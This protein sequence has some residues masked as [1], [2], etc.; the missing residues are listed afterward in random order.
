[1]EPGAPRHR[2]WYYGGLAAVVLALVVGALAA[3]PVYHKIKQWRA[4]SLTE[5]SIQALKNNDLR[6][7]TEAA[8]AALQM[9]PND[10]R[11]VRQAAIVTERTSPARALPLWQAAWFYYHN[12]ADQRA[13]ILDA[14]NAG[15]VGAAAS[16]LKELQTRTAN[17]PQDQYVESRIY[18]ALGQW[19]DAMDAAK[20]AMDTGQGPESAQ[21]VYAL[22]AQMS[23]DEALRTREMDYLRKLTQQS[24]DLGLQALRA[25][26]T[27]QALPPADA[28]LV[29]QCLLAHPL[30]TRD[31]KLLALRLRGKFPNANDDEI[32]QTARDLFPDN[33][34]NSLVT[35]GQWLNN[36]AKY[37]QALKLVDTQ[38]AFTRKDL[39][40]IRLD[41]MAALD[42][43]AAI[44][45]LLQR[46][47]VPLPESLL[48]MFRARTQTE[49]HRGAK[50]DLAWDAVRLAT[51]NKPAELRDVAKYAA[52]LKLDDV[53]R[54][55]YQ[56]LVD[57]PEQ[58]RQA[59]ENWVG[60]ER[61]GLHTS[62][63]HQVLMKMAA[64]YPND[65]VVRNDALYT[66][67]LLGEA[68]ISQILAARQ[69]VEKTPNQLANLITLALGYLRSQPPRAADA[70]KLFDG[71][72]INWP[73]VDP[74]FQAVYIAVLRANGR[75]TEA[76][77][78]QK[79]LATGNLLSE[80][81]NLLAT[82]VGT[83]AS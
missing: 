37:E 20:R 42:Q 75:V 2:A 44:D 13:Y 79:K 52:K 45:E 77:A 17:N 47:N 7:A 66:G 72:D 30:A 21:L 53:A 69:N 10:L 25:L 60:L 61:R 19:P 63:L 50:A 71:L 56:K 68:D 78:L 35:L 49:L 15:Q 31:D 67:F 73:V 5:K 36:Q 82:P 29:A 58:R 6:G 9:W 41:A 55:A 81:T 48:L 59:F 46:P 26:A 54:S 80:E 83:P 4:L 38:T 34:P 18:L 40:L 14:L 33:D 43:W 22:A 65:P 8:E 57:D 76:D 16:E 1:V 70:L 28:D 51:A 74:S 12:P 11:V 62:A 39:F 27:Y 23:T 3:R 32:L 64:A 24:D